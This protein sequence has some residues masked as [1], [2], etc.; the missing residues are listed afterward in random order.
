MARY[1]ELSY[2]QQAGICAGVNFQLLRPFVQAELQRARLLDGD[3][4]LSPLR[5]QWLLFDCL[6]RRDSASWGLRSKVLQRFLE[7][8]HPRLQIRAWQL[9]G[10]L[11]RLYDHYAMHRPE[12]LCDWLQIRLSSHG[13]TAACE[14]ANSTLS[15]TR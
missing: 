6:M 10:R 15:R 14:L 12:W 4:E 3:P 9:A 2:A 8:S 11:A 7:P 13:L 5:L 1:L